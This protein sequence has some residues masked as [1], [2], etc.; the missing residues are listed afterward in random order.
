MKEFSIVFR[1]GL[2]KGL[3][4]TSHNARN[5]EALVQSTGAV[6]ED[7]VLR[8]LPRLETPLGITGETFPFPQVVDCV[9]RTLVFSSMD[10][11]EYDGSSLTK[12][13]TGSKSGTTWSVADF[14]EYILMTNGRVL[15]ERDPVTGYYSER[16]DCKVP[17]GSCI[18]NLN[19]QL[20]VGAPGC[21]VTSG[22]MGE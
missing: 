20:I 6:P 16:L 15:V 9:K 7:G 3:R 13:F 2:A 22:F 12:V 1:G 11:Y 18:C 14:G 21:E 19:G 17:L 10:V 8:T 4:P 5:I